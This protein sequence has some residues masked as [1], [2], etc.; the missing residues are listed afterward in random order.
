LSRL[1][2]YYIIVEYTSIPLLF[3]FY[4]SYLSGKGLIKTE[5]VKALT[6]GLISYPASVF[7][8]TASALNFI[9][10]ALVVF[11]SVSGICLMINRRVGNRRFKM[12]A[13]IAAVAI[14][15]LY[16]LAVFIL[17]ELF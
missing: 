2:L 3:C 4:L 5:L 7:L 16:S 14:V 11:H 10:A 13:E 6:F 17:L 1:K 15:G 9:F 12:L 8:H